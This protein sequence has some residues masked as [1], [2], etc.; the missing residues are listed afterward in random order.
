MKKVKFG[1]D[2]KTKKGDLGSSMQL[3]G[4]VEEVDESDQSMKYISLL[5]VWV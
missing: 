5:A 4:Y 2:T 3:K 1:D